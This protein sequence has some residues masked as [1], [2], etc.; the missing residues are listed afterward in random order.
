MERKES[1]PGP[2]L[3]SDKCVF[4]DSNAEKKE[5]IKTTHLKETNLSQ[6]GRESFLFLFALLID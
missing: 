6:V 4:A 2:Y 3:E 1:S 5:S